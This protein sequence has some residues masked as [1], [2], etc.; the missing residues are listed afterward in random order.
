MITIQASLGEVLDKISILD[1]KQEKLGQK[2]EMIL[3]EEILLQL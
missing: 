3:L 1:L 2:M